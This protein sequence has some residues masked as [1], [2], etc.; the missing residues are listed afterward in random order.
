MIEVDGVK[1]WFPIRYQ[2]K[3]YQIDALNFIKKSICN[4]KRFILM[5][6]STG[7]GKSF[8]SAAMFSNWYKNFINSLLAIPK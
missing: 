1:I 7:S 5:N 6:L 2:P 4:K 3:Q 8:L